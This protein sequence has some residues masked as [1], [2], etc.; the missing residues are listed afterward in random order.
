MLRTE[1]DEFENMMSKF[2]NVQNA[3][4]KCAV[5]LNISV[6]CGVIDPLKYIFVNISYSK[7]PSLYVSTT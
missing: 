1:E 7:F 4:T 3:M 5:I 2:Y 6:T